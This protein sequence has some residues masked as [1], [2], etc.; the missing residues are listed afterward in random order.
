MHLKDLLFFFFFLNDTPPPRISPL[1]LHAAL[2]IGGPEGSTFFL[3][4]TAR[5]DELATQPSSGEAF[6]AAAS[7]GPMNSCLA[8]ASGAHSSAEPVDGGR[9]IGRAH[10]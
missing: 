1:P 2:P 5:A 4:T 9:Q 7:A 6:G 10:V 3:A 8:A